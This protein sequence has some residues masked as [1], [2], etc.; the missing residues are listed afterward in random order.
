MTPT[1]FLDIQLEVNGTNVKF[2][3]RTLTTDELATCLHIQITSPIPW[4]PQDV[5]IGQFD[6]IT[7]APLCIDSEHGHYYEYSDPNSDEAMLHTISPAIVDLKERII[8]TIRT[9]RNIAQT[10]TD[11]PDNDIPARRSFVS[12][13]RHSKVTAKVFAERFCIGTECA[14]ATM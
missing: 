14:K 6:T 8:A 7:R 11:T 4:D 2:I 5:Q 10:S 13:D 9:T 3:T 12:G 1:D